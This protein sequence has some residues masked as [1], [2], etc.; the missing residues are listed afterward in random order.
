MTSWTYENMISNYL[1]H[2]ILGIILLVFKFEKP[3]T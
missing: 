1:F 3:S 2:I